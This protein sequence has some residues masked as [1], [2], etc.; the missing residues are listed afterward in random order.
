L[1][2]QD[3]ILVDAMRAKG[4]YAVPVPGAAPISRLFK[5]I[6]ADFP[7]LLPAFSYH[8]QPA[9]LRSQIAAAVARIDSKSQEIQR[10]AESEAMKNELAAPISAVTA[11]STKE[12]LI[13]N[14]IFLGHGRSKDW[15]ELKDFVQD[16]LHLPWDEFNREPTA[17]LS[18]IERLNEMLNGAGFALLVMT[19]EDERADGTKHARENVIHEAGLF[20][21]RLGFKR[22][23]ILLEED[24]P[25]FSNIHG[26]TQLPFPRGRIQAVFEEV[27]RVLEREGILAKV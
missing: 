8:A 18:T 19:A 14:K 12:K 27:R 4:N 26:L 20:Q 13:G 25:E 15:I 23:I 22:A 17:G 16:R 9:A 6:N 1:I 24:C 11:S 21:G 2:S 5:H 7:D 3:R 10:E